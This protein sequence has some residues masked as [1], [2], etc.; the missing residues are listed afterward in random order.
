MKKIIHEFILQSENL[1]IA[2]EVEEQLRTVRQKVFIDFWLLVR[3]SILAA[4]R[5]D[6]FHASWTV[7]SDFETDI[8]GYS[9]IAIVS[10]ADPGREDRDNGPKR[11][12]VTLECLSGP[13]VRA[14]FGVCRWHEVPSKSVSTAESELLDRLKSSGFSSSHWWSGYKR[15]G[16]AIGGISI[17]I[18][19]NRSVSMLYDDIHTSKSLVTTI[20]TM[21]YNLFKDHRPVLEE[22]NSKYPYASGIER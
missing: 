1:K 4:L 3:D 18:N 12:A 14:I 15:I 20:A 2:L 5:R 21:T 16:P 7:Y 11:F 22:L 9:H 17:D 6:K 19:D 13:D 10:T 8:K